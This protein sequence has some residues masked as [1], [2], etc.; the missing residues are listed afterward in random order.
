MLK[1]QDPDSVDDTALH[2]GAQFV[3][4][5]GSVLTIVVAWSSKRS[6]DIYTE[7]WL[8]NLTGLRLRTRE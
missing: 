2:S 4:A 8:H 3:H 5:D 7:Y 6:V 1:K